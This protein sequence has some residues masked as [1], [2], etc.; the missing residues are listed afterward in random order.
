MKR[1]AFS[2]IGIGCL[3]FVG[4]A[5]LM[6]SPAKIHSSG[7]SEE[8]ATAE[9]TGKTNPATV[10][11]VLILLLLFPAAGWILAGTATPREGFGHRLMMTFT[12][13]V[14]GLITAFALTFGVLLFRS[15]LWPEPL[16]PEKD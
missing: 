7:F 1:L 5:S 13:G 2:L 9:M 10:V 15:W 14:G 3:W 4:L 12:A 6:E 8:E 11:T 16:P